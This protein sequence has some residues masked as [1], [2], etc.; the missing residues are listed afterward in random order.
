[1]Q[2]GYQAQISGPVIGRDFLVTV[3]PVQQDNRLPLIC[4]ESPVDAIGFRLHFGLQVVIPLD[5]GAR[6]G[7]DLDKRKHP[8]V[9]WILF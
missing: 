2:G 3:L 5:V 4:L 1:M 9:A 8:L 7:A 6:G